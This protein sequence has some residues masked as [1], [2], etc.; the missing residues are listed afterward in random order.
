M[1]FSNLY[2]KNKVF[3]KV[4]LLNKL[5]YSNKEFKKLLTNIYTKN[6]DHETF[7]T[8]SIIKIEEDPLLDLELS[9]DYKLKYINDKAK[10]DS[11]HFSYGLK[12]LEFENNLYKEIIIDLFSNEVYFNGFKKILL[13]NFFDKK[14]YEKEYNYN[15]SVP[16]IFHYL[17]HGYYEGKNPSSYFDASFYKEYNVN[18]RKSEVNPLVYLVLKGMDEGMVKLNPSFYQPKAIN[19]LYFKDKLSTLSSYGL[20][21][22]PRDKKVV[23]SLTSYPLRINDAKYAVYSL[24]NQ[25]FKPDKLILWL[26]KE[27]FPNREKDIPKDLLNLTRYGLD[28]R[29][30]HNIYSY[31]KLIPVL[32][33][34]SEEIIVTADDDIFYPKDWLF[35]LY[36]TYIDFPNNIIV[37][38]A[39]KMILESE[40]KFKEYNSWEL[41]TDNREASFL[42]FMTGAGGILYPP[43]ALYK[44]V[45][46][47]DKFLK[48]CKYGD[49]IWFW[50]M[51][52]LNGS[53]F[54]IAYDC[55]HDLIYINPAR[56][57]NLL[58][59]TT[60]W[61]TNRKGINDKHIRDVIKK[62]PEI[63][64]IIHDDLEK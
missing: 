54:K 21:N 29:W 18:A 22:K 3:S 59:E 47:E 14:Y 61:L 10:Q 16:P 41:I 2:D 46:D 36:S 5:I 49:D 32:K 15:L 26:A 9:E 11:A 45:F 7:K 12:K 17:Y 55:Y 37:H 48:L 33:E 19:R 51:A 62:Y 24:L 60:L 25:E 6:M 58:N 63:L 53:K 31:K 35:K 23:V 64:K 8:H 1:F 57:L 40:E 28:I 39:R 50:A 4:H 13:L 56:E 34:F 43:H 30:Y 44:D 52:V 27:E 38:R 42:T 20:N